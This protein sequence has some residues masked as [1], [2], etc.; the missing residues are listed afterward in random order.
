MHLSENNTE[1]LADLEQELTDTNSNETDPK[2]IVGEPFY[3]MYF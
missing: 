1:N 3:N 2:F